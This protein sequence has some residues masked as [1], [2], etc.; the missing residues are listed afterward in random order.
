MLPSNV[1]PALKSFSLQLPISDKHGD[2]PISISPKELQ[3]FSDPN[4]FFVSNG[5]TAVT[6]RVDVDLAK[7]MGRAATTSNSVN[8]R[9]ELRET[10]KNMS[11]ASWNLTDKKLHILEA[12]MSVD[13]YDVRGKG[14]VLFQIHGPNAAPNLE[15]NLKGGNFVVENHLNKQGTPHSSIGN[16]AENY[17]LGSKFTIKII[18]GNGM[19]QLYYNGILNEKV[20]FK[21]TY[22]NQYFKIGNYLQEGLLAGASSKVSIY[23]LNLINPDD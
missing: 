2:P 11:P 12:T 6:F 10:L 4:W 7:K 8:L 13:H 14:V 20:S 21:S 23:K 18:A 1:L 3:T 19:I 22:D 9:T 5:G 15:L 17:I 16:L